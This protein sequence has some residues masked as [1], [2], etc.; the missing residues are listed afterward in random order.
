MSGISNR[1]YDGCY[2]L[3]DKRIISIL[4]KIDKQGHLIGI[5][6][7][8][9]TYKCKAILENELKKIKYICKSNGIS[10]DI[11]SSRMHYLRW[12]NPHTLVICDSVGIK[13]DSTLG[14]SEHVGFRSG[15]C[16]PYQGFDPLKKRILN[17]RIKPFQIMDAAFINKIKKNNLESNTDYLQ[18]MEIKNQCQFFNGNLDILWHN[19]E[20]N[21]KY[22]I[23]FFKKLFDDGK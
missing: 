4:K 10:Q 1:N 9:E 22:K 14:F 11:I 21:T 5:H 23:R 12:Q 16:F 19:S 3:N 15:T 8:F 18:C 13:Y 7:S 6:P 20:L 2:D 17:I